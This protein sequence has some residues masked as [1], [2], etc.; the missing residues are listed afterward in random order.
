MSANLEMENARLRELI[1]VAD[2]LI[3]DTLGSLPAPGDEGCRGRMRN[4]A[5]Y[6]I[7]AE[8]A[9]KEADL[10]RAAKSVLDR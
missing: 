3:G 1:L 10:V 5:Q 2:W 8:V 6:L 4:K 7:H 9:Q